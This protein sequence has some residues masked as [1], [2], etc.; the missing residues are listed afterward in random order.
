MGILNVIVKKMNNYFLDIEKNP[1]IGT[2]SF[3]WLLSG[4]AVMST[5]I[6]G[7]I[8]M[9]NYLAKATIAALAVDS[10][11]VIANCMTRVFLKL[12]E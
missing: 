2:V 11:I 6:G 9:T 10:K 5:G 7:L 12:R 4:F 3:I 1:A 8:N